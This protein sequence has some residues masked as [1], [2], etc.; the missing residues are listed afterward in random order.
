[1]V[2]VVSDKDAGEARS[3]REAAWAIHKAELDAETA[4]TFET[5]MRKLDLITEQR[6]QSYRWRRGIEQCAAGASRDAGGS[7][8]DQTTI[9]G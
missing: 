7:G 4:V 2:G 9:A 1:M 5:A 8:A 6:L 3:A